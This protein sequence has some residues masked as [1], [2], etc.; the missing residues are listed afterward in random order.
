[1]NPKKHDETKEKHTGN[2]NDNYRNIFPAAQQN[3][4]KESK[5]TNSLLTENDKQIPFTPASER[6]IKYSF[7]FSGISTN[8][9]HEHSLDIS[10]LG[11]TF[12]ARARDVKLNENAFF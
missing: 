2:S 11:S 12:R 4:D 5:E 1:M 7:M 8:A 10:I 9:Q 3:D 6:K